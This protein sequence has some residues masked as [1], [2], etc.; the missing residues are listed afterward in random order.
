MD[1]V[2]ASSEAGGLRGALVQSGAG[3][4]KT[5]LRALATRRR[6]VRIHGPSRERVIREP[7]ARSS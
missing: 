5:L 1:Q 6:W 4:R 2:S 7:E 3:R